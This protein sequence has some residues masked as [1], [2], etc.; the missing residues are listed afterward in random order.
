MTIATKLIN[1]IKDERG[2]ESIEYALTSTVIGGGV[3]AGL[4][5]TKNLLQAKG[6]DMRA[7]IDVDPN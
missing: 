4:T 5:Q 1:F 2:A 3:A 6:E 7:A